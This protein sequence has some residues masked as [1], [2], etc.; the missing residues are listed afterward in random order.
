MNG[1]ESVPALRGI[2]GP[3]VF[4]LWGTDQ[5]MADILG[6]RFVVI[7]IF[8]Y[9]QTRLMLSKSNQ[10]SESSL[11][12]CLSHG[13]KSTNSRFSKR[14]MYLSRAT[15]TVLSIQAVVSREGK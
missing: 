1:G 9:S 6:T 8:C 2:E 10:P 13:M 12:L 14:K 15:V 4:T 11:T 5:H 3:D 7:V